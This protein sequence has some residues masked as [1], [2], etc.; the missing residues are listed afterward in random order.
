M[1]W[2]PVDANAS[3]SWMLSSLVP[4]A[5]R[6]DAN[7][8]GNRINCCLPSGYAVY[9]KVFHEILE[10][11]SVSDRSATWNDESSRDT[12]KSAFE[13]RLQDVLSNSVLERS[14]PDEPF[15][16]RRIS[17]ADLAARYGLTFH[18][19]LSHSS[20]SRRFPGRSWPRY[21]VGPEEGSLSA[22]EFPALIECLLSRSDG[23]DVYIYW[24]LP[25]EVRGK[26]PVCLRGSLHDAN[27]PWP[28]GV[29]E[30]P[31]YMWP[32]SQAWIVHTD[33][34]STHTLVAADEVLAYEILKCPNL[35]AV[36]INYKSRIDWSSDQINT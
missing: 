6:R 31:S 27:L 19:E 22:E 18:P 16:S 12:P 26:D 21:L 11:L 15:P 13:E 2:R 35:E 17:W 32:V 20:F 4:V 25:C 36:K 3:I 24:G 10:D 5:G 1:S 7:W 30:T 9:L 33:Y 28:E 8:S 23:Q 29:R 34:D 14:A